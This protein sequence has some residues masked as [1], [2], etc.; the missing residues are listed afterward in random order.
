VQQGD[1]WADLSQA[2][3]GST[4][5]WRHIAEANPGVEL[6]PGREIVIPLKP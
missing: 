3:Y 4:Q 6:T 5:H 2:F 1:T